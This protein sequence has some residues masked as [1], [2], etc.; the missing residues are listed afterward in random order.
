MKIYADLIRV[1][2][3]NGLT[4]KNS[5][6]KEVWTYGH[7]DVQQNHEPGTQPLKVNGQIMHVIN[8]SKDDQLMHVYGKPAHVRDRG[9]HIE[10]EN[11]HLDRGKNYSWVE[12]PGLLQIPVE[13]T[14]E[15]KKLPQ[16]QL[17]DVWWKKQMLFDGNVAKFRGGVRAVIADSR[18]RCETMDVFMAEPVSF[19]KKNRTREAKIQKVVCAGIVDFD[20]Y[21]Y[22]ENKLMQMRQGRFVSLTIHHQT[23]DTVAQGPGR[24]LVWKRGGAKRAR[25]SPFATAKANTPARTEKNDWE[26]TRIDFSGQA[27]GNTK[28]RFNTFYD[29]VRIVYGPVKRPPLVVDADNLPKNG[30]WM[31]S[32]SLQITQH[33]KTETKPAYITLLARGNAELD[34]EKFHGRADNISYDESKGLYI[35]KSFGKRKATIW[36]QTQIGGEESQFDAQRME[37]IPSKNRLKLDR[38]TRLDGIR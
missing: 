8:R 35:L 17:L 20:S 25:L 6:V 32:R 19:T 15:G 29:R 10:G 14:L 4:Q 7:V 21:E 36:R 16:P 22:V 3:V 23:G 34:G 27:L 5:K 28:Q 26:Y 38:T 9:R 2:I 1:R 31:R 12:G 24:I 13:K 30:G 18:M 37:F 33:E 11:I